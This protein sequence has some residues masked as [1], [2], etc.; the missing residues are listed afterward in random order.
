MANYR[1]LRG[2]PHPGPNDLFERVPSLKDNDAA[3]P[4]R[5]DAPDPW[6][7]KRAPS[8]PIED[9]LT[10]PTRRWVVALP[11]SIAPVAL[12]QAH[13]RIAS[14]LA[15]LWDDP[16]P[17]MKY[18][19]SLVHDRRGGRRGFSPA[20]RTE[21]E[22]LHLHYLKLHGSHVGTGAPRQDHWTFESIRRRT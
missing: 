1:P 14:R 12:A 6:A 22:R 9:T 10:L 15:R 21:L 3:T 13:P 18:L 2:S 5:V 8:S 19:D 16:A 11:A 20:I 4:A 17:C 7:G